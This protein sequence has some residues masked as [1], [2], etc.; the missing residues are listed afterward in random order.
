MYA[1]PSSSSGTQGVIPLTRRAGWIAGYAVWMAALLAAGYLLPGLRPVSWGLLGFSGVAAIGVGVAVNRPAPV[2]PWLLLAA[3]ALCL[4]TGQTALLVLT[5]MRHEAVAVPSVPDGFYLATYPLC[6]AGLLI[7]TRRRAVGRTW[8]SLLDALTFTVGLALLSWLYLVLPYSQ[9][10]ALTGVQKAVAIAYPLGDVLMLGVLALLLAPGAA[11]RPVQL[12]T[13]GSAGMLASDAAY[14]LIRLHGTYHRGTVVDLGWA[15]CFLAW[16]AAALHPDMTGM[17]SPVPRQH[18]ET[19]PPRLVLLMCASLIAPAVLFVQAATGHHEGMV[20]AVFSALLYLLV[21]TRLADAAATNRRALRRERELRLAGVSLAEAGSVDEVAHAVTSTVATLAGPRQQRPAVL[22]V[23]DGD[24]FRSA[25]LARGDPGMPRGQLGDLLRPWLPALTKAGTQ[26]VPRGKL[27]ESM[28]QDLTGNAGVLLCPLALSDRQAAGPL[29]GVL[30]VFAEQR[31][32][33]ALSATLEILASQAVLAMERI[34]LDREVSRRDSD[35]YFRTLVQ[36]TS[37]TILIVEDDGRIRYATPSATTLFGDVP[38]EGALIDDVVIPAEGDDITAVFSGVRDR[39]GGH[40]HESLRITRHDGAQVEVEIRCSDLRQDPTVGG[41]VLTLRDVSEQRKLERELKH[42]AFHDALTGLPNRVLFAD[43]IAQALAR[44]RRSHSAVGV[45][46]IDL[47]DFKLVNDTM[48]HGIGDEL[49]RAAAER[50][51]ALTRDGDTAARLGGDEFALLVEDAPS[52]RAVE[53][54]GAR[55]V[56]AFADPFPLST[57]SVLT[58]ATIGVAT[59][60]DSSDAGDLLRHADLALYAAKSAGKRQCR[61]YQPVLSVGMAKRRELQAAIGEAIESS[62]FTL[63]YQPIVALAS[64]AVVGFEALVRWPHPRWGMLHPDQFITLAEETGHIVPLGSWVLRQAVADTIRL[65]RRL[66][67]QPPLYVSVNVSARQ[68]ANPGFVA[69][70]RRVV[71]AAGLSPSALVLEL[72]ESVL[73]HRDDRIRE[74][75][76]ELKNIGIRLAID[77]FGT[78]YS[79]LGYLREL[80]MDVL[81]IDRSFVEGMAFSEQRL[82]IVEIIIRIAKTLG[83]AVV[84]EG[85][86]S[87]VQREL[88]ISLGCEYGQGYLLER[89]VAAGQAEALVRARSLP[90]PKALSG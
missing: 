88:L 29:V 26:L 86:E 44:A 39:P 63:V 10:P 57:G 15:L 65:Q 56:R 33:A 73:L 23:H 40:A 9:D 52:G 77:D 68:F 69:E 59:T 13:L 80:P 81:K 34:R 54:L 28:A 67:R 66:P 78:G 17:A 71:S 83:L 21:I 89:P 24:G 70:V 47:D 61:R 41:L 30:A 76:T 12:L 16:G 31:H 53:D 7:F 49:L 20:I 55:I 51:S 37:D 43:R 74:D 90:R 8:R 82:A 38:L 36:D 75:L 22:A 19:S 5:Q 62:A 87:E 46:F 4:A 11:A 2:A 72:T 58:T 42:R 50:L 14:G 79:S 64:D 1:V 45:L 27:P 32:L 25:G 85:I 35:A 6:A 48:G 18:A 3:G 60:E 84:A